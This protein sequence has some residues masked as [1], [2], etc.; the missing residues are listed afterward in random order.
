MTGAI[1]TLPCETSVVRMSWKHR[2]RQRVITSSSAPLIKRCCSF[3]P[4]DVAVNF[5]RSRRWEPIDRNCAS[6]AF[7]A[8]DHADQAAAD[9]R[10]GEGQQRGIDRDC[11]HQVSGHG[12]D[13]TEDVDNEIA[14]D[15]PENA[16][17]NPGAE[18]RREQSDSH[19]DRRVRRRPRVLG[20]PVFG[21]VV[22]SDC[23]SELTEE[24][25]RQPTIDEMPAS[26]R[27]AI[28]AGSSCA[29]I[30]PEPP[31]G[32]SS[33]R[34]AGRSA[35]ALGGWDHPGGRRRRRNRG[36]SSSGD[37]GSPIAAARA[38]Q[39]RREQPSPP[40]GGATPESRGTAPKTRHQK[41]CRVRQ[42]ALTK[43]QFRFGRAGRRLR[44]ILLDGDLFCVRLS[45]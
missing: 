28:R 42:P 19:G 43:E 1:S 10:H 3:S 18:H 27:R 15:I 40:G 29:P 45:D 35:P 25:V 21:V 34:A 32:C 41:A 23:K 11:D 2:A 4:C 13:V 16:D 9:D 33:R 38:N 31:R 17:E 26:S 37:I 24:V 44:A 39:Q 14:S 20:D 6:A 22:L 30:P 8:C 5:P 36:S 12:Q 7:F